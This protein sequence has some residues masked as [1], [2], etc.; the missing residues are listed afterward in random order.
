MKHAAAALAGAALLVS[1]LPACAPRRPD[2]ARR[3]SARDVAPVDLGGVRRIGTSWLSEQKT[4]ETSAF[5]SGIFVGRFAGAPYDLG[6]SSGRL[7]RP[8]IRSQE[9][10]LEELFAVL[11]PGRLKR[12]LIRQLS[13]FRLRGLPDEI[14]EDLLVAIAGLADG[15]EPVPPPSGWN[16]YRRMLDMHALHDVSQ[17]FV[18]APALAAACTGFLATGG[19]GSLLLARNFDF[20]GGDI[21]DRQKLVSVIVPADGI[22]YLSV[23]FAGMLGVVS[24]FNRAGIGVAIN[25][26]AG[27]ETAASGMPMTLLL[28]EVLARESTFEGAVARLG[29]AKVFVSDLI[30][31][32]DAKTGRFAVV[33]KSPSAFAVRRAGTGATAYMGATNEPEDPAVRRGARALPRGSTSRKRRARL[34]VLLRES[35]GSLDVPSA[36]AILRDRKGAD[37]RELGPGNR[38]AIDAS[39][40]AHSVVLDL[41]HRRAWVAASPHTL[42]SYLPVDLEAV[43]ASPG[44]PPARGT[45]FP[46]DAWLSAEG[47]GRYLEARAALGRVRRAE[48]ERNSDWLDAAFREAERA[49]ER[50]PDFAEATAKLG[51][52]EARRGNRARARA[53]LDD[54]LAY[55]PGP[56]PLR[57]AIERWRAACAA[58]DA[59]QA[60]HAVPLP[61]EPIPTV[62]QP[63]E[64][65]SEKGK[66]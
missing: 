21:F 62:P 40:A 1:C 10:L 16:A 44:G 17:R 25:A 7:A 45:P 50:A 53:L 43:L 29:S 64:L 26:I 61:K 42:G 24:G 49:H 38:N 56:V 4:D 34:E 47:Y 32:G 55:D 66:R 33:E 9:A 37:G 13:A 39:I 46:A 15:Y 36:I 63:D 3:G 52:M 27:G 23:G 30:L 20:E 65:L 12:S 8:E 60:G 51:E 2:T 19:D 22:P 6:Y 35:R 5:P 54:A 31:L 18:D 59:G 41:T 14:P 58:G 28:A 11:V 57:A 48:R